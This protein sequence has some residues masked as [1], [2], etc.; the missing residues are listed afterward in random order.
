MGARTLRQKIPCFAV[1]FAGSQDRARATRF[2]MQTP[3]DHDDQL[4]AAGGVP[5]ALVRNKER[6][7]DEFVKHLRARLSVAGAEPAPII[8]NTLPAFVTRLALALSPGTELTFA[9][10]YSNIAY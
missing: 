6:I 2:S 9:S 8:I 1:M 7:F 10:E 4:I 5:A 3:Q